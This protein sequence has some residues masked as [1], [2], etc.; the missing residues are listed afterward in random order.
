MDKFKNYDL[1]NYATS[2]TSSTS[3]NYDNKCCR[4]GGINLTLYSTIVAIL[5]S[6]DLT[7]DQLDILACFLQSIG[8]NLSVIATYDSSCSNK[9]VDTSF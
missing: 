8:Q 1:N 3:N 7:V 6:K 2:N 9:S 4:I 5:L